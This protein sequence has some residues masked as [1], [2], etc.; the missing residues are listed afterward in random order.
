MARYANLTKTSNARENAKSQ[1]QH[2]KHVKLSM[3]SENVKIV[4]IWNV[5][6]YY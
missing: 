4:T 6:R 2:G 3:N 1:N 5:K